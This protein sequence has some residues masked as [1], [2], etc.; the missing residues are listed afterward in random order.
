MQLERRVVLI[1]GGGTGIG[2]SCA[3]AFGALG[4]NLVLFGRRAEVLT[5]TA[6][7]VHAAGG[8][9]IVVAGDV[10]NDAARRAAIAAAQ[11]SFHRLDILI[12]NAGIVTASRLQTMDEAD[13]HRIIEVNLTAPILLT[14]LA[15]PLLLRQ[16]DAAVVNISS[17]M[18]LIALPFYSVY[19][20]AKAGIAR[21]G[22]ALRREL[23]PRLHCLTVYPT[24]TD[25]PMMA[26]SRV[27][28]EQGD[29]LETPDD[30]AAAILAALRTD[31][32]AV[33]RGGAPRHNMIRDSLENPAA[34][35][36]HFVALRDLLEL[37]TAN[38]RSV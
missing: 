36:A 18:G 29:M 22:E 27:G 34:V 15:L 30:V 16:E 7:L 33:I 14:K 6:Q 13:L 2:R 10:T 12:N 37:A 35:D 24:G 38:H 11:Q 8:H 9:A 21:F 23:G 20:A 5:E 26:T 31:E 3:T 1:T 28:A 25:T 19:S 17:G 32:I 4:A